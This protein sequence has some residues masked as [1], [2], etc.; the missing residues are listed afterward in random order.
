MKNM[1]HLSQDTADIL[2]K[3]GRPEWVTKREDPVQVKGK[4]ALQTYWLNLRTTSQSMPS[5]NGTSVSG[6]ISGYR[7][8]TRLP[9]TRKST[10]WSGTE[11]GNVLGATEV[12]ADLERLVN[13]NVEV[14]L[15]L[16]KRCVATRAVSGAGNRNLSPEAEKQFSSQGLVLDDFQLVIDMPKF[17]ADAASRAWK[18]DVVLVPRVME[19]LHDYVSAIASGYKKVCIPGHRTV[20]TPYLLSLFLPALSFNLVKELVP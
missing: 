6:D 14:L 12:D 5:S 20:R 16:L 2:I 7:K 18:E 3:N 19:E 8:I 13:W 9:K 11:L 17:D 4:G 10:L 1:I 15:T